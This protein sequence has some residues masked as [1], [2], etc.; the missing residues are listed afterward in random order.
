MQESAE[1]VH[2]KH[3]QLGA[4]GFDPG[5]ISDGFEVFGAVWTAF[6]CRLGDGLEIEI[7]HRTHSTILDGDRPSN[8]RDRQQQH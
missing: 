3:A 4:A 5:A 7:N 2:A 8:N 1:A 6:Y